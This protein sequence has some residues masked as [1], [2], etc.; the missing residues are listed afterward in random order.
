MLEFELPMCKPILFP[1][2]KVCGRYKDP[3]VKKLWVG[4]RCITDIM[5][6]WYLAKEKVVEKKIAGKG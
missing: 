1:M 4:W 2:W 6:D 3:G 5:R